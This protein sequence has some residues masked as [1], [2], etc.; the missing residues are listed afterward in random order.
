MPQP[1]S[2]SLTIGRLAQAAGVNVETVRYYERRQLLERPRPGRGA[3]R[4]YPLSAVAR[5]RFIKRA[6]H[7]GFT[8]SEIG[9]LLSLQDSPAADRSEVRELTAQKLESVRVRIADLERMQAA[10]I[11]LLR[12]CHGHGPLKSCPIIDGLSGADE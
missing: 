6:Q 11:K 2:T 12:L 1:T 4:H 8:L 7:L 3:F 9:E 10:L 5:I